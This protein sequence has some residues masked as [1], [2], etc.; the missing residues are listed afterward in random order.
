MQYCDHVNQLRIKDPQLADVLGGITSLEQVL[1]W[2]QVSGIPL[3]SIDVLAQDEYS[4]ELFVPLPDNR[5]LV[6]G[7]T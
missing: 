1:S 2:M 4:H 5:W 6:F 3:T 7:M